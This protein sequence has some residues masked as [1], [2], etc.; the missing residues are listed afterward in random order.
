MAFSK[1]ICY[2]NNSSD[3]SLDIISRFSRMLRKGFVSAWQ[4]AQNVIS[5]SPAPLIVP[6]AGQLKVDVTPGSGVG[7]V[8]VSDDGMVIKETSTTYRLTVTDNTVNYILLRAKYNSSVG[9]EIIEFNCLSQ[10][11]Y[12]SSPYKSQFIIVGTVDVPLGAVQVLANMI[13]YDERDR[14]EGFWDTNWRPSVDTFANLPTLVSDPILKQGDTVIVRDSLTIYGWDATLSAWLPI[15]GVATF[16]AAAGREE[17][18][19]LE[20]RRSTS[21]GSGVIAGPH[22][23][24]EYTRELR[25]VLHDHNNVADT[26]GLGAF[27]AEVNGH[28]ISTMHIDHVLD[29]KPVVGERYDLVYAEVYR[30]VIANP[31]TLTYDEYTGG[32]L[33][34]AQI[35]EK[36]EELTAKGDHTNDS[37][38]ITSIEYTHDNQ[39]VALVYSIQHISN[40]DPDDPYDMVGLGAPLNTDGQAWTWV[41]TQSDVHIW[42]SDHSAA[43]DGVAWGL[44]LLIVRRTSAEDHTINQ[45]I[46]VYRTNSRFVYPIY[47]E[48]SSTRYRDNESELNSS[49]A[50]ATKS[51]MS[52][53]LYP[54]MYNPSGGLGII[55]SE[56]VN[57]IVAGRR[58]RIDSARTSVT[59]AGSDAAGGRRDFVIAECRFLAHPDNQTAS[60]SVHRISE[61]DLPPTYSAATSKEIYLQIDFTSNDVGEVEDT[62]EAMAALGYTLVT[63]DAG[64][65]ELADPAY[66][67]RVN[68]YQTTYALPIAIVSR[69]NSTNF[70]LGANPNG[71]GAGSR[72]DSLVHTA[73]NGDRQV[74][75]MWHLTGTDREQL[76]EILVKSLDENLRGQLTT[77]MARHPSH[78]G[79]AGPTLMM[80]NA[81][82][83]APIAGATMFTASPDGFRHIWSEAHEVRPF[84]VTFDAAADYSDV[85]FTWTAAID[86]LRVQMPLGQAVYVH[87]TTVPTDGLHLLIRVLAGPPPQPVA[88][89]HL[90]TTFTACTIANIVVNAVDSFGYPTDI[91]MD[92]TGHLDEDLHVYFWSAMMRSDSDVQHQDNDGLLQVPNSVYSGTWGPLGVGNELGVHPGVVT[93]TGAGAGP[94]VPI[95]FSQATLNAATPEDGNSLYDVLLGVSV[96][97]TARSTYTYASDINN[98]ATQLTV[99][100]SVDTTGLDIYI[101]VGYHTSTCDRWV[102]LSRAARSLTGFFSWHA[103]D[104]TGMAGGSAILSMGSGNLAMRAGALYWRDTATANPW[105]LIPPNQYALGVFEGTDTVVMT[106]L[107]AAYQSM[108]KDYRYVTCILTA[109]ASANEDFIVYY[110]STPYQG[111]AEKFGI[112]GKPAVLTPLL[113]SEILLEGKTFVTTAGYHPYYVAPPSQDLSN[114]PCSAY[115]QSY[116]NPYPNRARSLQAGGTGLWRLRN[117]SKP[118]LDD[119]E[120]RYSMLRYLNGATLDAV[121]DRL[122]WPNWAVGSGIYTPGG[123]NVEWYGITYEEY[124][125]SYSTIV[126]ADSIG[127]GFF[128]YLEDS[129]SAEQI[130]S[131]RPRPGITPGYGDYTAGQI[132]NME[133]NSFQSGVRGL[134]VVHPAYDSNAAAYREFV[135]DGVAML[136]FGNYEGLLQ[137][138]LI[139]GVVGFTPPSTPPM[140]MHSGTPWRITSAGTLGKYY[141]GHSTLIRSTSGDW[142]GIVMMQIA[143]GPKCLS[144]EHPQSPFAIRIGGCFDAFYPV[145]RPLLPTRNT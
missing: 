78:A 74:V 3:A 103:T 122:P 114:Q 7:W 27:R 56:A 72:P 112:V 38:D 24:G 6:V 109:P 137:S 143:G 5:E 23:N 80:V 36:I 87:D 98:A 128:L 140:Y 61:Y 55:F 138:E 142:P 68:F 102:E 50:T 108:L 71:G 118:L 43:Y 33:T 63:G 64:L 107:Q 9:G 96:E 76:Q 45:A 37:F 41:G 90:D 47:P 59:L 44:P 113:Q 70:N 105:D 125:L 28:F 92:I 14:I 62:P 8:A 97:A 83:S 57:M 39:Y 101:L 19:E 13:S 12:T 133:T 48:C 35:T 26:V 144:G 4:D 121:V 75:Q 66:D 65:W 54:V 30:L 145:F 2:R 135:A 134:A 94:G 115:D 82:G 31:T 132:A 123:G 85:V 18:S 69:L 51:L 52:G 73:L 49:N 81:A 16:H 84:G 29:A 117:N 46:M 104:W 91:E 40:I 110:Q 22:D 139:E 130:G 77:L 88:Y 119:R 42:L 116:S 126:L 79:C 100:F 32:V 93:L 86:H 25:P 34:A 10:T 141:G 99:T 11:A 21:S 131:I 89:N 15:G 106:N 129:F 58:V 53:L 124:D 67:A 127:G 17:E 20:Y 120:T 136:A 1:F 111:I 60:R 95:A